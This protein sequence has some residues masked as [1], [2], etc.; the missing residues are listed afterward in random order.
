M[1]AEDYHCRI[2][3]KAPLPAPFDKS[4]MWAKCDMYST[5]ALERLD[6]FK[7]A[8]AHGGSPRKWI[9]GKVSDEQLMALRAAVLHGLGFAKS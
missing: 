9:A 6:R 5:V 8:R 1:P 2:V 4:T 7:M 3:L